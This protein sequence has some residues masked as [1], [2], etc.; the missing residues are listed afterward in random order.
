MEKPRPYLL[1]ALL[2]EKILQEKDG[3]ISVIRVVDR[4]EYKLEG[5]PEGLNLKPIV[6]LACFI[7]LKSGPVTGDHAI[8]LVVE[9]PSGNR[10]DAFSHIFNFVGQ[11]L[12]QNLI[13]NM[14]LGIEEQGL[15]WF[16]LFFDEEWLTRI[17]LIVKQQQAETPQQPKA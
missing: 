7:S 14:G 2:C 1:A 12:G 8:K 3:T 17:P 15:H 6:P 4:M 13:I 10:K 9:R 16:D 5:I 11:D